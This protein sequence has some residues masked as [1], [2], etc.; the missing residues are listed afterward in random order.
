MLCQALNT[1]QT[2]HRSAS[3]MTLLIGFAAPQPGFPLAAQIENLKK[4]GVKKIYIEGDGAE[5]LASVLRVLRNGAMIATYCGYRPLGNSAREISAQLLL[6]EAKERVIF[7]VAT[8]KRSDKHGGTMMQDALSKIHYEWTMPLPDQARKMG[9][10]GGKNRAAN[11]SAKR[12]SDA[13]ARSIW[14]SAKYSRDQDAAQAC[15]YGWSK[16]TLWVRFGSSGRKQGKRPNPAADSN[17]EG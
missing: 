14:F 11:V 4:Y 13:M 5:N 12:I 15:G 8:G 7:D 16:S 17:F 3:H 10:K 1:F 2:K 9:Q 6:V